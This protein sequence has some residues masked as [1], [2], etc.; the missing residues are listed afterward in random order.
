MEYTQWTFEVPDDT[1]D[2]LVT[3][4]EDYN[5]LVEMQAKMTGTSAWYQKLT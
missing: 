2:R 5:A 4:I 3:D 1:P